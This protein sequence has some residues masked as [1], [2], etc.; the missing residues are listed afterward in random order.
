MSGLISPPEMPDLLDLL[1]LWRSIR[2]RV[3]KW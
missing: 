2:D 3:W 1:V